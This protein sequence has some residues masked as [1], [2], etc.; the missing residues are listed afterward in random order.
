MSDRQSIET[1]GYEHRFSGLFRL[2]G[3][4]AV[5]M[6]RKAHVLTRGRGRRRFVGR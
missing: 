2:Y 1:G 3:K 4:T 5:D 6:L